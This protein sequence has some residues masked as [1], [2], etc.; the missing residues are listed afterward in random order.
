MKKPKVI[1]HMACSVNGKIISEHWGNWR[2]KFGNVYETC[3]QS[4]KS[5]A[6]M[7]GRVTLEKDFSDEEKPKLA[8]SKQPIDR[9][10][11]I[12]NKNAKSFAIAVDAGG[13]LG[14]KHNEISGDH[15]IEVLTEQ[16]DDAYIHYLRQ[17]NIS[18]IFAGKSK[19]NFAK[20]LHLLGSLFP[21][22]TIML[23]GG[24]LING[25]ML[26]A[27]LIDEVSLLLLPIADATPN[28]ATVFDL[29]DHNGKKKFSK[30]LR[31]KEVRKLKH[32]VLWITYKMMTDTP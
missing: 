5:Q 13:K 20:A 7:C 15:I 11:F 26:E 29:P 16:V 24:G 23:E 6:W 18:Y 14:W 9:K 21:I 4:F 30:Y 19:I 22:K 31:L 10:P 3:H 32:Q 17:R 1:C 8:K 12:G 27:E 28:T 2:A 25:S